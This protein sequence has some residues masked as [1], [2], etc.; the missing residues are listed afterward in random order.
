MRIKN[1]K[2]NIFETTTQKQFN[3]KIDPPK[4][5]KL[6]I[7]N[8]SMSGPFSLNKKKFQKPYGQ[9]LHSVQHRTIWKN[10]HG[11]Q[12][13]SAFPKAQSWY[14]RRL[15]TYHDHSHCANLGLTK[16]GVEFLIMKIFFCCFRANLKTKGCENPKKSWRLG[17]KSIFLDSF[18]G[19]FCFGSM[20]TFCGE[21]VGAEI[22]LRLLSHE[23]LKPLILDIA[24]VHRIPCN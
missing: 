22:F 21:W 5:L 1:Q 9:S 24:K 4:I 2:Y 11:A 12:G 20:L 17:K 3:S 16:A 19:W 14:L 18:W 8:I 13:S 7:L 6:K 15:A 23:S 10:K